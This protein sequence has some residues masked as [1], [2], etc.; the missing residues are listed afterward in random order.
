M[1]GVIAAKRCLIWCGECWLCS[2]RH[3]DEI[4]HMRART[5]GDET[6]EHDVRHACAFSHGQQDSAD[7]Q[8]IA[9]KLDHMFFAQVAFLKNSI[10][11]RAVKLPVWP[12]EIGER[13]N[14]IPHG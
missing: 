5:K 14:F 10:E 13:E 6:L 2:E 3:A 12:F 7:C 4:H 1:V 8:V 9:H 11:G